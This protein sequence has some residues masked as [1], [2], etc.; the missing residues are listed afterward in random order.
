MKRKKGNSRNSRNAKIK[1]REKFGIKISNNVKEALMLDK[2]NGDTKW[3][4]AIDKEL[5]ALEKLET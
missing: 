1:L 2:I 5:R 3:Q 4:D